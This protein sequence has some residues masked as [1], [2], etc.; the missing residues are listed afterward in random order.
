MAYI[1]QFYSWATGNT[2]TAERLNGNITNITDAL[3][4]GTKDINV[5]SLEIQ[6]ATVVDSNENILSDGKLNL[7]TDGTALD[8]AGAITFG[9][10][11]DFGIWWDG[12]NPVI[13]QTTALTNT[14]AYNKISHITSGTPAAGIGVGVQFEVET[15]AANNEIGGVLDIVTTDVSAASEDFDMVFKLMIAGASATELMRLKS[16]NELLLTSTGNNLLTLLSGTSSTGKIAFGD[17]GDADI[18]AIIYDHSDNSL[19]F[20]TNASSQM[21]IDSSGNVDIKNGDLTVTTG[22]VNLTAGAFTGLGTVRQCIYYETGAVA[23]G[24][25]DMPYDDTIPQNTEGD[26]YISNSITPQKTS[27]ILVIE[28]VFNWSTDVNE[29]VTIALFQ[30]STAGALASFSDHPHATFSITKP[31]N[32]RYVMTAGTTSSTTF[33]VRAGGAVGAGGTITFNGVAGSRYLG[34]NMKSSITITEYSI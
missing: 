34:G 14:I 18:G 17:S 7:K 20:V 8:A 25:T 32:F 22:N 33:K 12:S 11:Q 23:T 13:Q 5:L 10:G 6:G 19:D 9:A 28:V 31:T 1:S 3:S 2:I 29:G 27:N 16:T 24:T 21:D 26:E 30:D 4:Q 15:A